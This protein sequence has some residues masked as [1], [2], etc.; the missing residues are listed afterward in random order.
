VQ[1]DVRG[2]TTLAQ[3]TFYLVAG[4]AEIT[5]TRDL[6]TRR[7][8]TFGNAF[9]PLW[10]TENFDFTTKAAADEFGAFTEGCLTLK[11]SLTYEV[12]LSTISIDEEFTLE[13][14]A[15]AHAINLRGG[16]AV[17]DH[18]GSGVA[19]GLRDPLGIGGTTVVFNGLEPTN[20][21]DAAPPNETPSAPV[22]CLPGP[23]P[24]PAS[25]VIQFSTA[26]FTNDEYADVRPI[27][28]VTRTGGSRGAVTATFTT[29]DGTATG[30]QD[31][32]PVNNTVFFADG[33]SEPR[34]VRVDLV[35]DSVIEVD[36]TVILALSQPGGCAA[37]GTQSTAVLTIQD[38]DLPAPTGLP[39]ALDATF[40]SQGTARA[41]AFGGDRSAMALQS[42]GKI[43][44][45]GGT[46]VDFI[47]ARFNADGT[48]DTSFDA[49]GK[50]TTDMV[51]GVQ[52]EAL[53]VAIQAD[54]KIIVVGYAGVL[55]VPPAPSQFPNFALA[56]YNADGSLDASFGVGG[57]V[58]SGA[59]GQAYAVAIQPDGKIVVAGDFTLRAQSGGDF[60][61]F[62]LA[63][64]NPNGTL[65][66]SFNGDGTVG[67]D[68]AGVT[69]AAR[70]IVLQP[71]GAIVVSGK[72][73]GSQA[74]FDHTDVVRYTAG[75][76]LDTSFGV[77]GKLALPGKELE[78]GLA[79][80]SDG[81][82]VLVGRVDTSV[83][84]AVP[85]TVTEFALMRLNADGS[86]DAAFGDAGTAHTAIE[87]GQRDSANAVALQAD[88][89]IVVAGSSSNVNRD[90]AVARYNANG[91]LDTTFANQGKLTIDFLGF[92]D[93]AD[94]V[95][96][97]PDGKI[98]LG[99]LSRGNVD[100][101]GVARVLP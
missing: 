45:V 80:Q 52:E 3:R 27:V 44:M 56:R 92:T 96:I 57:K 14:V 83:A 32:T 15:F 82:L 48:L 75:G 13:S 70:N 41:D 40:G 81:K 23:G 49:D 51:S 29:S 39:G 6:W 89:R 25:G 8:E 43:V 78:G 38:D 84:P 2:W 90:F 37:L 42:D 17:S 64:Y 4:W 36:E 34:T 12:D 31:Y 74:G 68:I 63:R 47:L 91:T 1:L 93:I 46:T 28:A 9:S 58:V 71:N 50:V 53:G 101:Y 85:G 72:P 73:L 87:P 67:T 35:P 20:R 5:G 10:N 21:P 59:V 69:N 79:L 61:D 22:A 99:G 100:G 62:T 65:D 97:Q 54:G 16:G 11:E 30:G 77:G 95:A 24:D 33:D 94:S 66:A 76:S 7:A 19:A 86:P 55:T 88:G 18:Q 60:S 26:S 98:V